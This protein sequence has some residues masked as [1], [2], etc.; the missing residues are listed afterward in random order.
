MEPDDNPVGKCIW[1]AKPA[2]LVVPDTV[3]I[4]DTFS[5][6]EPVAFAGC[7]TEPDDVP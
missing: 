2:S 7:D 1:H 3:S 6:A 4:C 5:I